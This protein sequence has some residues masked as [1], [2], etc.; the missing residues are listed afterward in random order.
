[1]LQISAHICDRGG[2]IVEAN[3]FLPE[4]K[5]TVSPFHSSALCVLFLS[6]DNASGF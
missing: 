2:G 1:M 3:S 4:N 6:D 5:K